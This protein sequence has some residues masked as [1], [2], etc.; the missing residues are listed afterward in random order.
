MAAIQG[1]NLGAATTAAGYSEMVESMSAGEK[2]S[3]KALSINS[4]STAVEEG[5]IGAGTNVPSPLTQN[6]NIKVSYL[7]VQ[8]AKEIVRT[9]VEVDKAA[10]KQLEVS[11]AANPPMV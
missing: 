8:E 9:A 11:L 10:E 7:N 5:A 6:T 2:P 3:S 4:D 1:V